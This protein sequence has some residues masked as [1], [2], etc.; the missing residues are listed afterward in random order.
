ML[1]RRSA[2]TTSLRRW[3][4]RRFGKVDPDR[5]RAIELIRAV[6]AGG[7]PLDPARVNAIGRGLGLEVSARAPV[8]QTIDRIRQALQRMPPG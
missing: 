1:F 6:D 3:F 7:L 2:W 5:R 8:G 4:A